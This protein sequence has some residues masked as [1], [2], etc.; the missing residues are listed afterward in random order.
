M[1]LQIIDLSTLRQRLEHKVASVARFV[2]STPE[3]DALLDSEAVVAIGVSGGKD[4][5]AC[6]LAVARHLDLIGHTGPR[7]LVHADLGRVEWKDSAPACERLAAH[8]GWELLTVRRQAG[9]ML[10]RWQK[11]WENNVT[12]YRELSCVRLILPWSTPS[13]R[14][15]TSELKTAVITSALKK[16]YPAHDIVNV[17]GVRRQESSA[18][19]KMPVAAPLPALTRRNHQGVTWNAIIE[20]PVE[21]VFSEI[22]EAGLSLHEAYTRYGAS[23]VSC[24]FCIMSSLDDLRAAAGCADNHDLYRE[25]VAM[26]AA[27]TFAFQGQRWLADVSPD[28]L[29]PSLK[30]NIERAK[31][32]ALQRQAIEAEIPAHLLFTAGWPTVRPTAEEAALLASV[33]TRVA[34]LVGIDVDHTT[35]DSVAQ[36][37]DALLAARAA[38][39]S[40]ATPD[41][42]PACAVPQQAAFAF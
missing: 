20:W 14:F 19:S 36:R 42:R 6:A 17:T 27:S 41:V 8:L 35:A 29:S 37:Y 32:A 39:Q 33:R 11:R 16:R 40:L 23:R 10:A 21:D 15:C 18:R 7:V 24:A 38:A 13:M 22:A 9:D 3:V 5:V 30:A 31:V 4:S 25:M 1:S 12:R 26:E 28:L 2:T 34:A